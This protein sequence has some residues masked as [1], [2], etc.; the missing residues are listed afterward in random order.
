[1]IR[2]LVATA[3]CFAALGA[4]SMSFAEETSAEASIFDGNAPFLPSA[5]QDP[6]E[7]LNRKVF[8]FNQAMDTVFITP[9][10]KIYNTLIPF[11]IRQ[12]AD[13]VF[14]N[15]ALLPSTANDLLQGEFKHALNDA[16][17]FIINT[18]FGIGGI[19]DVATAFELP[20]HLNDMGITFARYGYRNSTYVVLPFLGPTT[21]RDAVGTAADYYLFTPYPY[22][23]SDW[24]I[25][26]IGVYRYFTI[27]AQLLDANNFMNEVALDPYTFA[28]DA[29]YQYRNNKISSGSNSDASEYLY[30][31]E[32]EPQDVKPGAE[33][34]SE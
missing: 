17:R 12:G 30:L 19:F 2:K 33:Y 10:S 3:I 7:S 18:T 16:W 26:G 1:M 9:I 31:N 23:K 25:T 6:L 8:D 14:D 27:K 15:I 22:I 32:N 13:N 24:L 28:R 34:V 20:E 4:A 29:Y 11:P 5:K 21:V